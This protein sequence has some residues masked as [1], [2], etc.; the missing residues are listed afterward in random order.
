MGDTEEVSG[1]RGPSGEIR[2][3]DLSSYVTAQVVSRS[4]LIKNVMNSFE[5]ASPIIRNEFTSIWERGPFRLVR[6]RVLS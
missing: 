4:R 2:E 5:F 1:L 3:F 6:K